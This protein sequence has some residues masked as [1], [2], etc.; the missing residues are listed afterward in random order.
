LENAMTRWVAM[1]GRAEAALGPADIAQF[2]A[3]PPP[4]A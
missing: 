4:K 2:T 3:L 1:I